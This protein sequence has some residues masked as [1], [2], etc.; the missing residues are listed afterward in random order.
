MKPANH[1]PT[2]TNGIATEVVTI[3]TISRRSRGPMRILA[4]LSSPTPNA[5]PTPPSTASRRRPDQSPMSA[6]VAAAQMTA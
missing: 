5:V 6:V 2:A 3:A 1:D 4:Q